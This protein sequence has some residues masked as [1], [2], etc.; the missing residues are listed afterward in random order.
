MAAKLG[1]PERTCLGC[2]KSAS[3]TELLRF[4][5]LDSETSKMLS[6]DNEKK[7]PGRGSWLHQSNSCYQLAKTR[8]AFQRALRS[9]SE[10]DYKLV[11]E[12]F[13]SNSF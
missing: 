11:D 8:K 2:R 6:P 5:L 13:A 1:Y 7:L 10:I 4:V 3:R 12:L 9:A